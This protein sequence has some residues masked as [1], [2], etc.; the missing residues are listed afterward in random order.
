MNIGYIVFGIMGICLFII[1][2]RLANE[3][4]KKWI[5]TLNEEEIE[6][7]NKLLENMSKSYNTD[8]LKRL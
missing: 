4:Y 3:E 8:M 2:V 1:L 6:N 5:D 7:Y